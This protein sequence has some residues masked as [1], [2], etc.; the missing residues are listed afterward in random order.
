MKPT[1][2]TFLLRTVL[3]VSALFILSTVFYGV[4]LFM[5]HVTDVRPALAPWVFPMEAYAGLL[6]API[7]AAIVILWRMFDTLTRNCAFSVDN[8]R[9]YRLMAW[10]AL[11]DLVLV[12]ALAVFLF[13]S[14]ALPGFIACCLLVA[15]YID[16]VGTIVFFVLGGLVQNAAEM[17]QDQD[18]TI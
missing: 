1:T 7:L 2:A 15:G 11:I 4:P 8:A 14:S 9:R 6:A 13:F 3:I 12:V 16:T 18:L 5:A 17:K 10:L